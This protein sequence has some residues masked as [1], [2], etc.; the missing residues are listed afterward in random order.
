LNSSI[1]VF[2]AQAATNPPTTQAA[3]GWARFITQSGPLLPLAL[4]F[5]FL[6]MFMNRSKKKQEHSRDEM[7]K[8]LKRGDRITTIGGIHGTVLRAEE[9]RVEVKVDEANNTKIW[10]SRSAIHKVVDEE[11]AE[12]K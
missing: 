11:K 10:F 8:Q 6:M 7:L 5:V 9:T 12:A 1:I 3:P 2:L 4:G